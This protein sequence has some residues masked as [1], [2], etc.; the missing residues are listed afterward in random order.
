MDLIDPKSH[1]ECRDSAFDG[2][3][4]YQNSKTALGMNLECLSAKIDDKFGCMGVPSN[5]R[6]FLIQVQCYVNIFASI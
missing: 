1:V 5:K 6:N 2:Q 4:N 3:I